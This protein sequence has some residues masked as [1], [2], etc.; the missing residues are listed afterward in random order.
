MQRLLWLTDPHLNFVSDERRTQL[1]ADIL[2]SQPTALLIGGDIAEAPTF[3]GFLQQFAA[4]TSVPIYFV[5]GNHDYYRSS[6]AAT[7]SVAAELAK[8]SPSIHWL[9]LTGTAR[10]TDKAVLIGHGC[11][12]DGRSGDFLSSG[13]ILN[14]YLLIEELHAAATQYGITPQDS[15][16]SANASTDDPFVQPSLTRALLEQLK[17]LGDEAADHFRAVLPQAAEQGDHI[18][19]LTHVPPFREACWHDGQISDDRW[20]PHFTCVAVGEVLADFMDRH[21][22]H[23]MTVLCG[24]THG[25]GQS[26]IRENL[27][28][29]TGGATYRKPA[30]QM[31]IEV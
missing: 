20:A 14:D 5:L 15:N 7:R 19:V 4:E 3:V 10:L 24:H 16:L 17:H 23:K 8:S 9:P 13:V 18:F 1:M 31:L 30:I 11:W 21:P 12:A 29:I 27:T 2:A 28:V 22:E 26:E 25:A 6:I